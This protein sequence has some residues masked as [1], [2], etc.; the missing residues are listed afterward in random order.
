MPVLRG[1]GDFGP[2]RGSVRDA[3]STMHHCQGRY[4]KWLPIA[5][6]GRGHS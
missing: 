2:I 1:G 6:A 3:K 5:R 4:G